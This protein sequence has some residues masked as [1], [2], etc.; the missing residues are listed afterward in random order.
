MKVPTTAAVERSFSL[1]AKLLAK[2][3]H[4]LPSNVEKY[5]CVYYNSKY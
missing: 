5:L 3:R 2:D 4:F 1:L